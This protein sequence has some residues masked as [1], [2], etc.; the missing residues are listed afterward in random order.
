VSDGKIRYT[1]GEFYEVRKPMASIGVP[2]TAAGNR[3][4]GVENIRVE[5][6]T[7]NH[8][9]EHRTMGHASK[10]RKAKS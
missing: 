5:A 8:A 9:S 10:T 1:M 6:P 7:A 2:S 3:M 4:I